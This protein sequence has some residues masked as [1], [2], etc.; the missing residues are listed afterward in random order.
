MISLGSD[1]EKAEF[2]AFQDGIRDSFMAM[3]APPE[4]GDR[5]WRDAQVEVLC[6]VLPRTGYTAPNV[7]VMVER[8]FVERD[9]GLFQR[10]PPRHLFADAFDDDGAKDVLRM[11]R[12]VRCPT[13]IIRCTQSGAPDVLDTELEQLVAENPLVEVSHMPLTHM[14]PAWDAIDDVV[15]ELERFLTA[16]PVAG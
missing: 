9:D 10:R 4:S 12:G 16:H 6:D 2:R 3:T 11:Y 5:A 8:N 14:A 7:R 15:D 1:A 13:L